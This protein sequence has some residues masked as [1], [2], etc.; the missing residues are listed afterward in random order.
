MTKTTLLSAVNTLLAGIGEAPIQTL[1]GPLT[2]D[3]AL[4]LNTLEDV[5]RDVQTEGWFCNTES[6]FP[7]PVDAKGEIPVP[8]NTIRL[9]FPADAPQPIVIRG[10][11]LYDLERHTFSFESEVT[12]DIVLILA[13]EDLTET[14]RQYVTIKAA[15]LFQDRAVGSPQLHGFQERDELGARAKA[16]DEDVELGR[17][18][19]QKGT[20]GFMGGWQVAKVLQR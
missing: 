6:S 15:R 2:H 10:N 18:N 8:A 16:L 7:L 17:Y 13:F 3:V 14:L 12:A 9:A 1:D 5:G 19:V 20:T 4:A 11:R